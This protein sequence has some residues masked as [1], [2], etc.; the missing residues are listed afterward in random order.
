MLPMCSEDGNSSLYRVLLQVHTEN[1]GEQLLERK[2]CCCR[3][4][5]PECKSYFFALK[6][7]HAGGR[8]NNEFSTHLSL[9]LQLSKL[10]SVGKAANGASVNGYQ[11]VILEGK[12]SGIAGTNDEA[13]ER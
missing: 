3:C 7:T 5:L 4:C 10:F 11:S 8:N 6:T 12:N 1:H 9:N 13:S 2:H